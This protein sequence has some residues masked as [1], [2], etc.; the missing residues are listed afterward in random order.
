MIVTN[1][2]LNLIAT[3]IRC[4]SMDIVQKA[5]SGHPG[6]PMGCADIAAVLW[7]KI[8]NYEGSDPLWPNRDRFILSAGHG[9]ALLYTMLHLAGYNLTMDDLK[10]FRQIGS[11]TPGHPEFNH[12]PG[13]ET[14]TG[15]LGQGF[16]NGVGMA[17]ASK[18]MASEFNSSENKIFDHFIYILAGD[19]CMME[20]ISSE[21]GSLAGHM[22]L[23]NLICIYDSNR[24]TIEGSTDLAFSEDIKKRFES[25]GWHV[26]EIDGHNFEEIENSI[27]KAQEVSDRPSLIIA[28]TTIAK[29][30]S[31][32]E[33]S[34]ET[35][36]APLGAD[37]IKKSK[38][39][40]GWPADSSFY[41]PQE[42]YDIFNRVRAEKRSAYNAWKEKFNSSMTSQTFKDKWYSFFSKVD[43]NRLKELMPS[44]KTGE[45]IATRNASGKVIEV[46][47][48]EL[49]NFLGGSADLAPSNKTFVK[50]V[51]ESGHGKTGKII[52]FG[53]RE[54]AMAAIQ[55]GLAYYGGFIPFSATFFVFMDY[56]RPAVRIAALSKLHCIYVFTHD[57]IF[58]GEDGPTHQPVEHLAAARAIPNLRVIR[59]CD[60]IETVE[61]WLC[62]IEHQGPTILALSR[63][64][65]PV[66][67]RNPS[68]EIN[69]NKGAYI[70]YNCEDPDIIIFASGS[71]VSVSIEAAKLL[72]NQGIK[73]RVV[74]FPCWELFD[75]QSDDYKKT[76]LCQG[77]KKAVVEA[78]IS[79]G[80]EKY[81]GN[82]AIFITM[83]SFGQSGPAEAVAE[84][85]G[86]TAEKI[87]QKIKDSL[88]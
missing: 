15:P 87:A 71:E 44:F 46:L 19:G 76:I 26:E 7:T 36:G 28:K 72:Q 69:L 68:H 79:M 84:F 24:I 30:S 86:F 53:V 55:N 67:E 77:T 18:L 65:L 50:N 80:W 54:H 83:E 57:S 5:N 22:K 35:H 75:T 39:I 63:Q 33:G 85:Y 66:I 4:L 12:T 45:K 38:E 34:E 59:P 60:A 61:A 8:M 32:M 13:V 58:V 2:E 47:Y 82:D 14:T 6:M 23:G 17:I 62:A 48:R 16:A 29:G 43:T 11:L 81:A 52:H 27:K 70:I 41:V 51:P 10:N 74:S 49:P 64:N 3:T 25:Q 73:A 1:D 88:K 40:L 37:E 78:G 42:V 20:G 56:L 9:S 31:S 21:A